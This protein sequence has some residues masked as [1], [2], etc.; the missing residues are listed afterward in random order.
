MFCPPNE[1]VEA[2]LY[3]DSAVIC[4][5]NK[6]NGK[7]VSQ[8]P[9]EL[10]LLVCKFLEHNGS[11]IEFLPNGPRILEDDLVSHTQHFQQFTTT[12]GKTL[13]RATQE[14]VSSKAHEI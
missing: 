10:Q 13:V 9:I 12:I 5:D 14:T 1:P 11:S 4:F 2:K 6:A 7:P 3:D 8:V